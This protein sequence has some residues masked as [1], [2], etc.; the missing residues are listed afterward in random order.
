MFAAAPSIP[1]SNPIAKAKYHNSPVPAGF[2]PGYRRPS[3]WRAKITL[4]G[5]MTSANWSFSSVNVGA[6]RERWA[7]AIPTTTGEFLVNSTVTFGGDN[8][9]F[10]TLNTAS[11]GLKRTAEDMGPTFE[12][13]SNP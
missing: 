10:Q 7:Y 3:N 2:G 5:L 9:Y 6:S 11:V 1:E 12:L 4:N 8:I 13:T